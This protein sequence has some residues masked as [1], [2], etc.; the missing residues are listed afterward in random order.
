MNLLQLLTLFQQRVS[1]LDMAALIICATLVAW[2]WRNYKERGQYE[3]AVDD[4]FENYAFYTNKCNLT[5]PHE[6]PSITCQ[7]LGVNKLDYMKSFNDQ[8]K[9]YW[10][11]YHYLLAIRDNEQYRKYFDELCCKHHIMAKKRFVKWIQQQDRTAN[12]LRKKQAIRRNKAAS[13]F[14]GYKV[15]ALNIDYHEFLP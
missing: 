3:D 12:R 2:L 9:D 6:E 14:D 10:K 5:E 7:I 8:N 15:E 11:R 4:F 1:T 13:H